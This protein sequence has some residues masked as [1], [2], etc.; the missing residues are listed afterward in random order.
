MSSFE[1]WSEFSRFLPL[2]LSPV[3]ICNNKQKMH[4]EH[5]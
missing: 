5:I 2:L 4:D 1:I 3:A